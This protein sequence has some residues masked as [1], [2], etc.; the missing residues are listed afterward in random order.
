MYRVREH[1]TCDVIFVA[2][3]YKGISI[4]ETVLVCGRAFALFSLYHTNLAKASNYFTSW[5]TV[6]V[7]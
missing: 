7:I 6:Y 2:T 1:A 4:L 3:I 5:P